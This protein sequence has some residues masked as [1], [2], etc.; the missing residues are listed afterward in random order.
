MNSFNAQI[1]IDLAIGFI[2]FSLAA[3]SIYILNDVRD[4]KADR[5]HPYKNKRAIAAGKISKRF[6]YCFSF[7]L[8]ITSLLI[9]LLISTT[10]FLILFLYI[11]LNICY[12]YYFK[13]IPI[14]DCF[15]LAAFYSSRIFFGSIAIGLE[16]PFWLLTFS[17]YFFLSLSLAKRY[18]E[19][20][21]MKEEMPR[22]GYL[23]TDTDFIKIFGIASGAVSFLILTLY[24]NTNNVYLNF[25]YPEVLSI[26]VMLLMYW[27]SWIWLNTLRG[28][29]VTDPILYSIRDKTS[30]II[31]FVILLLFFIGK[32]GNYYTLI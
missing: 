8:G 15:L 30:Q 14:L 26:A 17:A 27:F 3:S 5:V 13:R 11:L 20:F 12:S 9:A 31:C 19:L 16:T 25:N 29:I 24:L 6:A 7:S 21:L 2:A 23:V 18:S 32:S 1:L 28:N 10:I 22:R 4:I